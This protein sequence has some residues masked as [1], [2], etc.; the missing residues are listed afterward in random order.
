MFDLKQ[1]LKIK[2]KHSLWAVAFCPDTFCGKEDEDEKRKDGKKYPSS[3]PR[4]YNYFAT[5]G[6]NQALIYEYQIILPRRTR[7]H[8]RDTD[9]DDDLYDDDTDDDNDDNTDTNRTCSQLRQSYIS[10]H[11]EED[12]FAVTFAHQRRQQQHHP[13][14]FTNNKNEKNTNTTTPTKRCNNSNN[15]ITNVI[16]LSGSTSNDSSSSSSSSSSSNSAANNIKNNKKDTQNSSTVTSSLEH[17]QEYQQR[18]VLCVGGA[19]KE[20]LILDIEDNDDNNNERN[21][22]MFVSSSKQKQTNFK[23][24]AKLTGCIGPIMDLQYVQVHSPTMTT[25]GGPATDTSSSTTTNNVP[26]TGQQHTTITGVHNL[27]CSAARDEIKVWNLDTLACIAIYSDFFMNDPDKYEIITLAWHPS[28][29]TIISAGGRR[30]NDADNTGTSMKLNKDERNGKMY[31]ICVWNVLNSD[32]VTEAIQASSSGIVRKQFNSVTERFPASKHN[33]VHTDKIDCIGYVGDLILSKSINDDIRLWLPLQ[34][35]DPITN[36]RDPNKSTI[37]EV[38]NYSYPGNEFYFQRFATS[39]ADNNNNSNNENLLAIGS[40]NGKVYMWDINDG[41]LLDGDDDSEDD[42]NEEADDDQKLS[43]QQQYYDVLQT[44]SSSSSS[45]IATGLNLAFSPDGNTLVGCD[46]NGTI[47]RW[48]KN[49]QKQKRIRKRKENTKKQQQ[50]NNTKQQ[51]QNSNEEN[52]VNE[53]ANSDNTVS[54]ILGDM[55]L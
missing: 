16:D 34:V 44:S 6:G 11:D 12:F 28:G 23:L 51:E 29:S 15:K 7:T 21:K 47:F 40:S 5:V 1:R 22:K 18:R 43:K 42:S 8:T 19:G 25:A 10:S 27:L 55:V 24:I 52:E 13:S 9:D 39:F 53:K 46:V 54:R 26:T 49:K 20:I 17:Q 37:V 48:D 41:L 4:Y 32:R 14:I 33:D 38:R 50:R 2:E 3:Y 45:V 35:K 31:Q 30:K 36:E